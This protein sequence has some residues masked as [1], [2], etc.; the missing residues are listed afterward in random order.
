MIRDEAR[1]TLET[2]WRLS[3]GQPLDPDCFFH[4]PRP[5]EPPIIELR[6]GLIM[7]A[8]AGDYVWK[9]RAEEITFVTKR[10]AETL[11]FILPRTIPPE[12]AETLSQIAPLASEDPCYI[13]GGALRDL[14]I[15]RVPKDI[16]IFVGRNWQQANLDYLGEVELVK[17]GAPADQDRGSWSEADDTIERI[18]EVRRPSGLLYQIIERAD[19]PAPMEMLDQFDFGIC[20]IAWEPV[21][22][23][24][25]HNDFL[26]DFS[27][28]TF[29]VHGTRYPAASIKRAESFAKRFPGWHFDLSDLG[30]GKG[31][32][33]WPRPEAA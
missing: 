12:W 18:Y 26:R 27:A 14:I 32:W 17:A 24:V 1:R 28:L 23:W 25:I 4:L 3:G 30:G 7:F 10:D 9:P 20:R 21:Y 33:D 8:E 19:N 29:T 5:I 31:Q 6:G 15:G 2:A 22:G 11:P 13:A 16:D